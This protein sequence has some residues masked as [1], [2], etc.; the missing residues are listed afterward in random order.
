MNELYKRIHDKYSNDETVKRIADKHEKGCVT[1]LFYSIQEIKEALDTKIDWTWMPE[2]WVRS[3]DYHEV[4]KYLDIMDPNNDFILLVGLDL[5]E[6]T[7]NCC[8]YIINGLVSQEEELTNRYYKFNKNYMNRLDEI[9]EYDYA[10]VNLGEN[11]HSI[12]RFTDPDDLDINV[13]KTYNDY[14]KE[15]ID[16][17]H[18]L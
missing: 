15:Q 17:K 6:E 8:S 12:F 3:I 7:L 13:V 2:Y 18:D 4:N 11:P 14:M 10:K 16:M 1:A 5:G 9:E